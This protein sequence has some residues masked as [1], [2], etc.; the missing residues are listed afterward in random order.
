MILIDLFTL[1]TA[2]ASY[3]VLFWLCFLCTAWS[4]NC[5]VNMFTP[6]GHPNGFGQLSLSKEPTHD[7]ICPYKQLITWYDMS[8]LFQYCLS[9]NFQDRD[10]LPNMPNM[11]SPWFLPKLWTHKHPNFVMRQLRL[12]VTF[13]HYYTVHGN[14]T[15]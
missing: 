12:N 11:T 15:G 4:K 7:N 9:F 8:S 10:P 5:L 6:N 13:I 2:H 1:H 3:V 14:V